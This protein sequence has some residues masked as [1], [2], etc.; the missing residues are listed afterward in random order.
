[1]ANA[2]AEEE[3]RK[4]R[5]NF[6]KSPMPH[7]KY[8]RQK[9]E[10]ELLRPRKTPLDA[11][12][13]ELSQT[14]A[15]ADEKTRNSMR[16]S[17]S[18]EEFSTLLS[19]SQRASVFALREK[20][21]DMVRDGLSAIAMIEAKRVDWRDI[22]MALSLLY[23]SAQR[24]GGDADRIFREASHLSDPEVAGLI[25][26]FIKR[27]ARYKSLRD[28]WGYDE[29]DID[30]QVGYIRYGFKSYRPKRNL[31]KSAIEI[32][33]LLATDKYC[34][35]HIEI[36]TQLPPVWLNTKDNSA[37]EKAMSTIRACVSINAVL[38]PGETPDSFKQMFL[39]FLVE[40]ADET[41]AES[42]LRIAQSK[43]PKDFAMLAQADKNLFCIVIARSPWAD[44]ESFETSEKLTRFS[45]GMADI[46]HRYTNE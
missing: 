7:E 41:S 43:K 21:L 12:L 28:S 9:D 32:A 24:I 26:D 42:L 2:V 3:K 19:F 34:P 46:L 17:I 38:N 1:M 13:A 14:F 20:S 10:L 23:H 31:T 5:G 22:L 44:V 15:K 39:L 30:D 25:D 35:S 40:T 33:D 16:D 11:Q 29:V 6:G 36:A 45:K 18:M 27:D 8:M 4:A 37:L